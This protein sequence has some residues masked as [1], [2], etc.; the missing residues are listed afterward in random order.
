MKTIRGNEFREELLKRSDS[1]QPDVEFDRNVLS[2][3]ERVRAEGDQAVLEF[4][5]R[6]D[7]VKLVQ[8]LVTNEE[9]REAEQLV[10]DDFIRSLRAAK[11]RISNY[12]E[13]QKEQSWFFNPNEGI[14]LGQKVTPIDSVG[15]Y[16]PGGKA[17]YPSTVLMNALPAKIAGV[18]QISMVTPPQ[19]DGKINP[20][21]LVAAK[22]A[23][24][25]RIY[26]VGGA[27]AIAALAYGTETI[28]KV[29]KITGPGN[30]Y[31][32]RAKKWVFGD[33]AI[34]MIAGPSEIC[35][36]ADENTNPV[37]AAADLLS[38]AEHDE[39]AA[40]VCITTSESFAED[41]SAEVD[42]QLAKLERKEIAAQSIDQYGRIIVVDTLKE[43]F[44][45]V[46]RLAPEHLELMIKNPMEHL[47]SIRNAGAIFL[48]EHAPEALGDYMAGPNH[49]LPTSGTAAFSSPLGVYDFMKKSSVIYYSEEALAEVADDVI[50]LAEAEQLNGHANSIKV[51]KAGR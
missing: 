47:A 50:V 15:L 13:A 14:M 11:Q 36:V 23:G 2:I 6:F 35:V 5:E 44:D 42:R 31:V 8:M 1:S 7:G 45:I 3:I 32:A 43:A 21:V 20:H 34:D 38:Q 19:R 37:Y 24:V 41:L 4:T 26:K 10:T 46:N 39:R 30:A 16:V 25:D 40:A 17:A 18:S 22:E 27:Q 29:V 49:T 33:V 9:I 28:E 12:H 51:R 48:G